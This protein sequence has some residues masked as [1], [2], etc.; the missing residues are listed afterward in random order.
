MIFENTTNIWAAAACFPNRAALF[1]N[2]AFSPAIAR[3]SVSESLGTVGMARDRRAVQHRHFERLFSKNKRHK[4]S[5]VP[6]RHWHFLHSHF[7]TTPLSSFNGCYP[8]PVFLII[9]VSGR[10]WVPL[11]YCATCILLLHR[12]TTARQCIVTSSCITV[13]QWAPL[14][15][16]ATLG[17]LLLALH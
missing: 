16:R 7:H 4:Y 9:L 14:E 13:L 10:E 12:I 8:L 3:H 11:G 2:T 5:G 6:W 1:L 15:H 17:I